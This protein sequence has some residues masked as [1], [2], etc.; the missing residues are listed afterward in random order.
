[1]GILVHWNW[2]NVTM[3]RK[4]TLCLSVLL[5]IGL[6][7]TLSIACPQGNARARGSSIDRG[8][9]DVTDGLRG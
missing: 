6:S 2:W 9:R 1:M 5:V 4:T 8:R 7:V 3:R